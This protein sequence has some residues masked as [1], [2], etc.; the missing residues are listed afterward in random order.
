[1]PWSDME[2]SIGQTQFADTLSTAVRV[3]LRDAKGRA[4]P[5][6]AEEDAYFANADRALDLAPVRMMSVLGDIPSKVRQA[7]AIAP[8][9]ATVVQVP[10][11]ELSALEYPGDVPRLPY[12]AP[13]ETLSIA[14]LRN[15]GLFVHIYLMEAWEKT[16][17]YKPS[18]KYVYNGD[19]RRY[20][21]QIVISVNVPR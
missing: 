1:M 8:S 6:R 3:G 14:N 10:V 21:L 17:N 12:N 18:L 9:T 16:G 5:T 13:E 15:A 20:S 19:I 7:I 4:A 2:E 11:M